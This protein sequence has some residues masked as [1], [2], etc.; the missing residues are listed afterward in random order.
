MELTTIISDF[1]TYEV[2]TAVEE[3]GWYICVPCGYKRYLREGDRFPNCMK[4]FG[5][6]ENNYKRGL[7]RW[8]RVNA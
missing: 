2:G 6:E 3:N 7:E 1:G 4:C 8:E 5:R